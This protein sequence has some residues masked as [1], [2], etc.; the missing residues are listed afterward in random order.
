MS[1]FSIKR[2]NLKQSQTRRTFVA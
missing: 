1:N 2:T